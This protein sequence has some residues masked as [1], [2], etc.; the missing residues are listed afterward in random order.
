MPRSLIPW[1]VLTGGPGGGKSTFL[2]AARDLLPYRVLTI[3]ETA[4]RLKDAA[5][6]RPRSAD[7]DFQREVIQQQ[8]ETEE[9]LRAE[10]SRF[11]SDVRAVLLDRGVF[12]G[13]AF[14]GLHEFDALLAELSLTRDQVLSRYDGFLVFET[15][16]PSLGPKAAGREAPEPSNLR[17][18]ATEVQACI[19]DMLRGQPKVGQV[20]V[21]IS[22]DSKCRVAVDKLNQ[23]LDSLLA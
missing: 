6:V 21:Q 18:H 23:L 8:I 12:D 22:A 16:I 13:A 4:R 7:L 9:A 15:C 2:D 11:S 14:V 19:D 20:P 10:L 1:I 5:S 17:R 3:P